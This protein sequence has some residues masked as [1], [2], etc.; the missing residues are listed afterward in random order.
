M[1]VDALGGPTAE[2]AREVQEA[3][4]KMREKLYILQVQSQINLPEVRWR[5]ANSMGAFFFAF[6]NRS[7]ANR[8]A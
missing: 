8:R 2:S 6:S 7:V 3:L 1:E 4:E 5:V